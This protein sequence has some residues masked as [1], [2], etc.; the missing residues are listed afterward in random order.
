MTDARDWRLKDLLTAAKYAILLP[1]STSDRVR[2]AICKDI[3]AL[4]AAPE[5]TPPERVMVDLQEWRERAFV[6]CE[7]RGWDLKPTPRL[8]FHVQ[9]AAELCEATRGKGG[10]VV[11][12]AGDCL[13]TALAMIPRSVNLADVLRVNTEKVARLMTAP[14]Y[15]GEEAEG[16]RIIAA[17][18]Q[19]DARPKW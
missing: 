4:L 2:D 16:E 10:D 11:E 18:I 1:S 19:Q 9:E 12:E 15:K 8:G 7:T 5:S 14:P 13:F 17:A 3:D 6:L